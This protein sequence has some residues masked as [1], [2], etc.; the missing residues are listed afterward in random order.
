M[1][2]FLCKTTSLLFALGCCSILQAQDQPSIIWEERT[3]ERFKRIVSSEK[4]LISQA[5]PQDSGL[6]KRQL[7]RVRRILVFYR[8]EGFIHTS[9]PHA[10]FALQE[11]ARK[12]KAFSVDLEDEYEARGWHRSAEPSA[13]STP[14]ETRSPSRSHTKSQS[15]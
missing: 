14:R 8:C 7:K 15:H 12:S 3:K 10:N 2:R 13:P 1:Q 5:Q 11:M 4:L 9:I 6:K